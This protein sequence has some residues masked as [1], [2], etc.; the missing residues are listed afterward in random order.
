MIRIAETADYVAM[1]TVFRASTKAFCVKDYG[2]KTIEAWAGEPWPERFVVSL[3]Q[4]CQQ[5]VTLVANN[6]ACFGE[7]NIKKQL[8]LSLFVSPEH[9]GQEMIKFLFAKAITAGIKVLH[10]NSSLNAANFYLRNGFIEQSR[11]EFT[12]QGGT[13]LESIKMA[14]TLQV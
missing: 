13:V 1:D 8:L 7:L 4:G 5:Y 12:T 14:C 6:L 10:V 2:S 3:E 11:S 9:A